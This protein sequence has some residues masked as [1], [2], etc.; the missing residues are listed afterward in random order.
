MSNTNKE[1]NDSY[2]RSLLSLVS[3]GVIKVH[4]VPFHSH[5]HGPRWS[6]IRHSHAPNSRM[7]KK[8]EQAHSSCL[9][10][11]FTGCSHRIL[12]LIIYWPEFSHMAISSCQGSKQ[13]RMGILGISN[14]E[15]P[16]CPDISYWIM[17]PPLVRFYLYNY[18]DWRPN[19]P[20]SFWV[21]LIPGTPQC[22]FFA[23]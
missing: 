12:L 1:N 11:K 10:K 14:R 8:K 23:I 21:L 4:M 3:T 13:G 20:E 7:G 2:N 6:N 19:L 15:S 16:P 5:P 22:P 18:L 17:Y 9:L